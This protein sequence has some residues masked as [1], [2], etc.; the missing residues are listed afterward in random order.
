[1]L[2]YDTIYDIEWAVIKIDLPVDIQ[3][4]YDYDQ[5]FNEAHIELMNWCSENNMNATNTSFNLSEEFMKIFIESPDRKKL[6]QFLPFWTF[7]YL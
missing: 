5:A 3:N 1:M 2:S 4:R 6:E 7:K